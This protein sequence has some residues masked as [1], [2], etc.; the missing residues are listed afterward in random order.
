MSMKLSIEQNGKN[1]DVHLNETPIRVGRSPEFELCFNNPQVSRF[2]CIFWME[3]GR[4]WI[5]DQGSANG[6]FVDDV[7][8][9]SKIRLE[10]KNNQEIKLGKSGI[11]IKVH[12][13]KKEKIKSKT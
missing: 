4:L 3:E 10:L 1:Q 2:H 11:L 7:R 5:Q 6:T 8:L 12:E 9:E 13:K